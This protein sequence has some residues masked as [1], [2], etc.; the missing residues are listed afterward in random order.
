MMRSQLIVNPA[1]A[2]LG[3]THDAGV[4]SGEGGCTS[5]D[6]GEGGGAGTGAGIGVGRGG[7]GSD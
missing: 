5:G 7:T 4:G 1:G 6:L 3:L 2:L